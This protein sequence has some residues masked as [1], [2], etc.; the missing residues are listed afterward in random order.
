MKVFI[1]ALDEKVERSVLTGWKHPTSTNDEGN[2]VLTPE[3]K[4]SADDYM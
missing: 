1:K 2:V 3:V 4:W